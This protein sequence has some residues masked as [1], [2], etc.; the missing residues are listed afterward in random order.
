MQKY[1][2]K[3]TVDFVSLERDNNGFPKMGKRDVQ[4]YSTEAKINKK[5]DSIFGKSN[6]VILD[7]KQNDNISE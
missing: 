7:I 3:I 2:Y 5:L 6:Y 1:N 4:I